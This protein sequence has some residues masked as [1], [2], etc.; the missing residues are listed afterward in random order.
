[1]QCAYH[2]N[3]HSVCICKRMIK[4]LNDIWNNLNPLALF[5]IYLYIYRYVCVCLCMVRSSSYV[6]MKCGL[7]NVMPSS[8]YPSRYLVSLSALSILTS[9]FC[10]RCCCCCCSFCLLL[11]SNKRLMISQCLCTNIIHFAASNEENKSLNWFQERTRVWQNFVCIFILCD[12]AIFFFCAFLKLPL[13]K[14]C[15]FAWTW[16]NVFDLYSFAKPAAWW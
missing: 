8:F 12:I 11:L 4:Y 1:M 3:T 7:Y 9:P 15:I 13:R 16:N 5:W 6:T 14:C 10:C 2:H